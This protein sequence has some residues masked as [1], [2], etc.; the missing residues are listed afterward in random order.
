MEEQA[1]D[2]ETIITQTENWVRK[3]IIG[4]NY[5]PFAKRE[6]ELKTVRYQIVE[7]PDINSGLERL[8][9][10]CIYLDEHS[11]IETTLIIYPVGL[12]NFESY[13]DFYYLAEELLVTRGYRG[14]YQIASFH[15]EYCFQ[16][17]ENNDAA[18]YTNRSPY[19]ML[20]IIREASIE[21]V[22]EHYPEPEK[23]PQRNIEFS[24]SKGLSKM[25]KL[26]HDCFKL[27]E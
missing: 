18:N 12:G 10:E 19:P 2:K 8:V 1:A 26:L 17:S 13:L 23:I 9:E 16:G 5:C 25:E 24:R 21:K 14:V 27:E 6:I 3:V 22:L 7:K 11:S 20:H 15:P 4:H